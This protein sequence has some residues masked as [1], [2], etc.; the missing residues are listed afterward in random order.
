MYPGVNFPRSAGLYALLDKDFDINKHHVSQTTCEDTEKCKTCKVFFYLAV[1]S[2]H[3]ERI[4][5][6]KLEPLFLEIHPLFVECRQFCKTTDYCFDHFDKFLE[7]VDV[8]FQS[9]EGK[10]VGNC[11]IKVAMSLLFYCLNYEFASCATKHYINL[12]H[13]ESSRWSNFCD[14]LHNWPKK[15]LQDGE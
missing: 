15:E 4:D 12:E 11:E 9:P 5:T 7:I 13:V 3:L 1:H 6:H 14:Y 10:L 8:F 2:Y